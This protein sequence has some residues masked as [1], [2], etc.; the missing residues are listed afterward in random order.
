MQYRQLASIYKLTL[1]MFNCPLC[2][3]PLLS[4]FKRSWALKDCYKLCQAIVNFLERCIAKLCVD[5]GLIV[6][7]CC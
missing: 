6:L 2:I 4:G 1:C 5:L 3:W 7:H